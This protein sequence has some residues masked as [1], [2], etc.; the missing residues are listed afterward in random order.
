[1]GQARRELSNK[2]ARQANKPKLQTIQEKPL[3]YNQPHQTVSYGEI[4]PLQYQSSS[5]S[6]ETYFTKEPAGDAVQLCSQHGLDYQQG[7]MACANH[8]FFAQKLQHELTYQ[9]AIELSFDTSFILWSLVN[10]QQR[11]M[12]SKHME[13]MQEQCPTCQ[14][15]CSIFECNVLQ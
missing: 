13:D 11:P 12:C 1:V 7:C 6:M 4:C 10:G 14:Q 5:G 2:V 8:Q 9:T 15:V 3:Y